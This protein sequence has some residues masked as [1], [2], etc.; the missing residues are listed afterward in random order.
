MLLNKEEL[1]K[2]INERISLLAGNGDTPSDDNLARLEELD[3]LLEE[4][5]KYI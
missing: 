5:K 2:Y 4:I 3:L 1:T